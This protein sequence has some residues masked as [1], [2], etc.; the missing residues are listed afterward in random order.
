MMKCHYPPPRWNVL[1]TAI[2]FLSSQIHHLTVA[3]V[4]V[5]QIFD[6]VDTNHDHAIS[7]SELE[8]ALSRLLV[9]TSNTNAGVAGGGGGAPPLGLDSNPFVYQREAQSQNGGSGNSSNNYHSKFDNPKKTKDFLKASISSF[10]A[11]IA[12][13]IGDKTFFIAAVLS[14][15]ND[16]IAVFGGAIMAL[17][18]MTIVRYELLLGVLGT[19]FLLWKHPHMHYL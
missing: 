14:M 13:E 5:Q 18:I 19:L 12:T 2:I 10:S 1:F 3:D 8:G 4:S 9:G 17:I 6:A 15:R 7:Q 16:R 11:I